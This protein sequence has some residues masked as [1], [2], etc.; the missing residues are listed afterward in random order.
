MTKKDRQTLFLNHIRDIYLS[1]PNLQISE[2]TIYKELM[3]FYE[4]GGI[5]KRINSNGLLLNVQQQLSKQFGPNFGRG[6]YFWLYENRG[7][8]KDRDF[9]NK[10]YDGIKLYVSVDAENLYDVTSKII[11][12]MQKENIVT[13]SKVAKEMRN[14]VLVIKVTTKEEATKV[15]NYVNSLNYKSKIKPNPF[16][17]DNGNVNITKE[18]TLSY[19]STLCKLFESYLRDCRANNKL[20]AVSIEELSTYTT[21][22]INKLKGPYK[23][24]LLELYE[25]YSERDYVDILM[26][27]NI[28]SKNLNGTITLEDIISEEKKKNISSDTVTYKEDK[29]KIKYVLSNLSKYYDISY[30]H[31]LIMS[32]INE[33]RLECFTRR[34]NMRQIMQSIS[35]QK[36]NTIINEMGTNALTESVMETKWKYP[37]INQAEYAI[38]LFIVK[39]D[40]SGFT[41]TNNSRSY[42]GLVVPSG[43]LLE[44]ISNKLSFDDQNALYSIINLEGEEREALELLFENKDISNIPSDMLSRAKNRLIILNNLALNITSSICNE[45]NQKN[46]KT[47]INY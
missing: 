1:N 23:K 34:D 42:L 35:P 21:R 24:E 38:K 37:D 11:R 17:L 6:G 13:Q 8:S 39:D 2:D 43:K 45:V 3:V 16:T 27:L 47:L 44:I 5:R 32:Y 29:E 28:I 7:N 41:N 19:N 46:Y 22:T 10:L 15:M 12:Y 33:G 40:L 18:G 9:Y 25:L 26:I 14:D 31:D 4:E 30:I 36:L 20:D